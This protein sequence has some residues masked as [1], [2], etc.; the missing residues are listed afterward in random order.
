M[1]FVREWYED[2]QGPVQPLTG[3]LN[4]RL[5]EYAPDRTTAETAGSLAGETGRCD[6]SRECG[7]SRR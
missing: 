6:D 2:L 7:Y 3:Q 1:K 4:R 5:A